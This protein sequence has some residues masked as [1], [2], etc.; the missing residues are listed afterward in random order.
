MR[1][2]EAQ[3]NE[4]VIPYGKKSELLLADGTKV[5]LNAGSRMAFPSKFT[6]NIREVFL[7]GEACFEVEE[8]EGQPFIV[9][10]GDLDVKVLGTHFNVSA[11]R[12]TTSSKPFCWKEAFL[13][14][15]REHWV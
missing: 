3:M 1:E 14:K 5:W 13:W 7:E 9:K 2:Q 11:T 6:K 12:L 8:N 4:V 10:A 15:E